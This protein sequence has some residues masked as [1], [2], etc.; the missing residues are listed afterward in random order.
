MFF[1]FFPAVGMP[2]QPVIYRFARGLLFDNLGCAADTGGCRCCECKKLPECVCFF[3][4]EMNSIRV[5]GLS[6]AAKLREVARGVLL[7]N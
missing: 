7:T 6:R 2:E 1:P 4:L 5:G 3:F